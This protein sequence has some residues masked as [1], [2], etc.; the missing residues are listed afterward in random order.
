LTELPASLEAVREGVDAIDAELIRLLAA[1][2]KLMRAAAAAH[3][4]ARPVELAAGAADR[5]DAAAA[6]IREHAA[7]AG[8]DPAVA[9]AAWR[10]MC[11][12]L[13]RAEALAWAEV[14]ARPVR[15]TG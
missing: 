2:S 10:A 9:E 11:A 3:G 8:L 14:P 1:R 5:F 4:D 7:S 15:R 12:E 13:A 6:R